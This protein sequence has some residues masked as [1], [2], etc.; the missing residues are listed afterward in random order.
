MGSARLSLHPSHQKGCW[1]GQGGGWTLWP[2]PEA[3][4]PVDIDRWIRPLSG[5]EDTVDIL[6]YLIMGKQGGIKGG[7][8]EMDM[9]FNLLD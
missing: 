1:V 9:I 2:Q 6:L 4:F 7:G 3:V 8:A 5:H